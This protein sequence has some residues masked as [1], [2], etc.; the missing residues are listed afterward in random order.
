MTSSRRSAE[1]YATSAAE[2]E[3][4]IPRLRFCHRPVLLLPARAEQVHDTLARGRVEAHAGDNAT[5]ASPS[6]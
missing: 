4:P 2:I 5:R 6:T 3:T 1:R